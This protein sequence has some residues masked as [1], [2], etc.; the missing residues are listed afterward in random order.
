MTL[1][2]VLIAA[3]V[4]VLLFFLVLGVKM[5]LRPGACF[6]RACSS[7]D[8]YTGGHAGCSCADLH[9]HCNNQSR[10]PYQPL[11]VNDELMHEMNS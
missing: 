1:V 11:Q 8:P 9:A 7:M 2:V 6:K 3:L 5:L 4:V 10:H